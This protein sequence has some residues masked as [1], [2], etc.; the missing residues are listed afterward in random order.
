VKE[1]KP[2]KKIPLRE[3]KKMTWPKENRLKLQSKTQELQPLRGRKRESNHINQRG[4]VTMGVG[5]GCLEGG[6]GNTAAQW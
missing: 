5:K 3:K 2:E 6:K 1:K 4:Q